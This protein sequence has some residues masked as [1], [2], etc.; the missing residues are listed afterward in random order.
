[1]TYSSVPYLR[2]D[3][4]F[5]SRPHGTSGLLGVR[6]SGPHVSHVRDLSS[7]WISSNPSTQIQRRNSEVHFLV[8]EGEICLDGVVTQTEAPK[9]TRIEIPTLDSKGIFR[10]LPSLLDRV[11]LESLSQYA[12][13]RP[14]YESSEDSAHK[15]VI[16]AGGRIELVCVRRNQVSRMRSCDVGVPGR[17]RGE[18]RLAATLLK[19]NSRT[20]PINK[21]Q[22]K[23]ECPHGLKPGFLTVQMPELKF[24]PPNRLQ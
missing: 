16:Q 7:R 22:V 2:G 10:T 5:V 4:R 9:W 19:A 20:Y 8:P 24:R 1:L 15:R 14:V 23:Q 21:V 17:C 3:G 12:P 18:E 6:R 13:R 11:R